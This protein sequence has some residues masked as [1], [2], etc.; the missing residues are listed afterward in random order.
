MVDVKTRCP[1]CRKAY[2]LSESRL[3]KQVRCKNCSQTF[4][5]EMAVDETIAPPPEGG[6]TAGQPSPVLPMATPLPTKP[7]TG[8]ASGSRP[9]PQ[10]VSTEPGQPKK[11]G[12]YVVRRKLGEGG[13]GVVWLAHDPGLERDV[14]VKVLPSECAKDELYL[15]RFLREA[16][17]AAKL[18][19]PNTVT[20]Y[21][22]GADG[23]LVYLAME[24]VDG[25]SLAEQ[26]ESGEPMDWR[27]ATRA[28]RDAAAGLAAAHEIGLVHRDIKPAN[29][30]R[31]TSGVTKVVDF[32]LARVQ[33]ANTQLTQQGTFL[34][35]P[36]YMAPEQWM[37][38]EADARTD[39]YSLVC[40]YYHLLTGQPPYEAP[41]IPALGYQHRYEPIPDPR[42]LVPD[43]PEAVCRVLARGAQKAPADRYQTAAELIAALDELSAMSAEELN[44]AEVLGGLTAP[45]IREPPPFPGK[46]P[47][48]AKHGPKRGPAISHTRTATRELQRSQRRT[49][50]FGQALALC[51]AVIPPRFRTPGWLAIGAG[52]LGAVVLLL[53]IVFYVATDH[54]TI[55]IE[56]SDLG[57]QVEVRVDGDEIDIK[58]PGEPVHLRVGEHDLCVTGKDYE[59]ITRS[60]TVRRAKARS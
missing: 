58:G 16:R 6:K 20:I 53:G 8:S 32:G 14:A 12:P 45:T 5:V 39:L 44:Y 34:G 47:T 33:A 24:L 3:G 30:M 7:K 60:F 36:A 19:H 52:G 1:N 21:Q 27:E 41:S 13:M 40:T 35:T 29:L 51:K 17:A 15:K 42:E 37:G 50:A 48:P 43:L 57:A 31:T 2:Q 25:T 55:K 26:I 22:V 9:R 54:G 56:L 4:T 49:S 28:I 18:S 23:S 46:A 38:K 10:A 59:T 11:I